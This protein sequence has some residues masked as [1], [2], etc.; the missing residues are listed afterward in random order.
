VPFYLLASHMPAGAAAWILG[1]WH[2]LTFALIFAVSWEVLRTGG[3]LVRVGSSLFCAA[4]G[5]IGPVFLGELGTSNNDILVSQ[6]VLV[7]VLLLLRDARL[8]GEGTRPSLSFW[9]SGLVLGG[10]VGL[11]LVMAVHAVAALLALLVVPRFRRRRGRPVAVYGVALLGG[12]L[13]T[14]G[15]WMGILWRRFESP[16]FPFFNAVFRSPYY[17]ET[18]FADRRFL[19]QGLGEVL[20]H[21]LHLLLGTH[22]EAE[23][24]FRDPRYALVAVLGLAALVRHAVRA[25]RGGTRADSAAVA[26]ERFVLVFFAVSW[27]LW[28][29]QFAILRYAAALEALAPLVALLLVQRLGVGRLVESILVAVFGLATVLGLRPFETDRIPRGKRWIQVQAPRFTHPERVLVIVA[30]NAPWAFAL[31][32]LQPEIRVLGLVSNFTKPTDGTRFQGEMRDILDRHE[33]TIYLL[34]DDVYSPGDFATVR[35]HYALVPTDG[36]C[37]MIEQPHQSIRL[38]LCPV[39]TAGP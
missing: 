4:V 30:H 37:L 13:V 36:P 24:G 34:T 17:P 25:A 18:N 10:A 9:I 21:P 38:G 1:A 28:L 27:A 33:G 31:T 23:L 32:D 20:L 15:F 2:G 29:A 39:E 12:F 3:S 11:K 35:D 26:A 5:T 16:L 7:A 6:L 22:R 19:P 8:G 14:A